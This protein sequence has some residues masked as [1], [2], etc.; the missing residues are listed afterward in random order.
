MPERNCRRL[1]TKI[2]NCHTSPKGLRPTTP[3]HEC[4]ILHPK[5]TPNNQ[6]WQPNATIQFTKPNK[7]IYQIHEIPQPKTRTNRYNNVIP[8]PNPTRFCLLTSC[9]TN[10]VLCSDWLFWLPR[11]HLQ[12]HNQKWQPKLAN[13]TIKCHNKISQPNSTIKCHNKISQPNA[14][15]AKYSNQKYHNQIQRP[16][17]ITTKYRNQIQLPNTTTKY[18]DQVP[19]SN[20]AA[21]KYH[22]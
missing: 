5:T 20:T 17:N 12:E 8:E 6:T 21:K 9:K 18:H 13:R 22:Q 15:P 4:Q 16:Q 7:Q 14:T 1:K 2:V 19:Q 3:K 10:T 11:S